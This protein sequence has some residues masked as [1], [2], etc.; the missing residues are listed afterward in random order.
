MGKSP[1][2]M[3]VKNAQIVPLRGAQIF[4]L[5]KE[6]LTQNLN[7]T[8]I[9]QNGSFVKVNHLQLAIFN[10][11]LL[12]ENFEDEPT[13]I[14]TNLDINDLSMVANFITEGILPLPQETLKRHVPENIGAV[15]QSFGIFLDQVLNSSGES[16]LLPSINVKTELNILNAEDVKKEL[17]EHDVKLEDSNLIHDISLVNHDFFDDEDLP[18]LTT[19]TTK[20]KKKR[21]RPKKIKNSD[22][23]DDEWNP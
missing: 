11:L 20:V 14:T 1:V 17:L 16:L 3:K 9:S 10:R 13:V 4:Y 19:T 22:S 2:K 18:L 23:E 6:H 21:G 8:L 15:F 7:V 12:N 5:D